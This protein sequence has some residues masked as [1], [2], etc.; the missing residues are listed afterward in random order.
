MAVH[1]SSLISAQSDATITQQ[2]TV[3]ALSGGLLLLPP[4]FHLCLP[5]SSTAW[6]GVRLPASH[7]LHLSAQLDWFLVDAT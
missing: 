4:P 7:T 3:L 5:T 2:G 1:G 6:L